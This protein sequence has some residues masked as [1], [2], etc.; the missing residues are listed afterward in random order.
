MRFFL[1]KS[2]R[3]DLEV[4]F[5]KRSKIKYFYMEDDKCNMSEVSQ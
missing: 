3:Y 2:N 5:G 4:L 1:S